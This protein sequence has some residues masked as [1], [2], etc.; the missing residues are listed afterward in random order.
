MMLMTKGLAILHGDR[1]LDDMAFKLER[2]AQVINNI[3]TSLR[4]TGL[5]PTIKLS[6][7]ASHDFELVGRNDG[8]AL[9]KAQRRLALAL[10]EAGYVGESYEGEGWAALLFDVGGVKFAVIWPQD[11]ED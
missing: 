5:K 8:L 1:N 6:V 4:K 7:H 2:A 11:K 9:G 10:T 3:D